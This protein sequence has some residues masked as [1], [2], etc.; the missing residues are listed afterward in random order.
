MEIST[1][2][3]TLLALIARK[4]GSDL[5]ESI[6]HFD[7]SEAS[8]AR[9]IQ[10]LHNTPPAIEGK[11]GDHTTFVVA[12]KGRDF[13]LSPQAVY[14]LMRN[15]Y[16][17]RCMPSWNDKDLIDKVNNAF[18]YGKNPQGCQHP[19]ADFDKESSKDEW[20][21]QSMAGL[22]TISATALMKREFAEPRWGVAP[23]LPEGLT[24]LAGAPKAG[25]SWMSLAIALSITSGSAALGSYSTTSGKVLYFGLEDNFRRLQSRLSRLSKD[26]PALITDNLILVCDLPRHDMGGLKLLEEYLE[27]NPDCKMVVIDTW[28]RFSPSPSSNMNQYDNDYRALAE[29][30]KLAISRQIAL[31]L[32]THLRKQPSDDPL[33]Q[34]MGSTA[35]PGAADA[36]WMLKR[37]K[38]EKV[39]ALSITGRDVEEQELAVE[40]QAE[41][42]QWKVLGEASMHLIGAERK[43]IIEFIKQHGV[44]IGP[45]EVAKALN[46]S[47]DNIKNL[48]SKMYDVGQLSKKG[49]GSYYVPHPGN[50]FDDFQPKSATVK[51]SS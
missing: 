1:A 5:Y 17:N 42:C 33:A 14:Q 3:D 7:D 21:S 34:I 24:I 37:A 50:D 23:I 30:Q 13:G 22:A 10:Y 28:S 11:G 39:G 12:C 44:P 9:Y 31:V 45:K 46:H 47:P 18:R 51:G 48:M 43:E 19:S 36:I 35:V 27:Q 29:I 6:G 8:E 4:F 40:F 25:K 38:G 49:R 41:N 32:I 20:V 15:H 16:N 26:N 2:S